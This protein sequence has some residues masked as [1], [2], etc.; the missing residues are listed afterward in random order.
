M[1]GSENNRN[2]LFMFFD[3]SN[4]RLLSFLKIAKLILEDESSISKK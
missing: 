3:F 1:V 4:K 2:Y